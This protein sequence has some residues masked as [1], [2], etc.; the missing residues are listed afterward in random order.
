MILKLK[1]LFIFLF[2]YTLLLLNKININGNSNIKI[3][4]LNLGEKLV[5]KK[6]ELAN[7]LIKI[8]ADLYDYERS[9]YKKPKFSQKIVDYSSNK[10]NYNICICSIGKNENLYIREFVDYYNKMGLDKIFIYDNNDLEGEYFDNILSDYIKNKFVEIIDVRGLSSIQIP[11]YNYCY[12]KNRDIYDWIGFL[13]FDEYLYI[14]NN[15]SIKSYFNN[16]RFKKC[17]TIFLNWRI[18]SDNDLLQY[19]NRSLLDRFTTPI[20]NHSEGKSFVRGKIYN[21]AIPT[22]H[23]PGINLYHFCNSNG[24]IIKPKDFL[25]HNFEKKPKAYIKHFFTKTVREFCNKLNKGNAHY[26]KNHTQYRRTI[27]NRVKLFFKINRVTKE[28]INILENCTKM[29]FNFIK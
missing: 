8:Y 21:L 13:D 14:K 19:D 22:T 1:I 17:Q 28:K 20:I 6:L 4:K 7:S 10:K 9:G 29:K 16:K 12:H 3:E 23:I 27:I 15:E 24:K 25:H 26:H 18:F 5:S 11:I 2:I